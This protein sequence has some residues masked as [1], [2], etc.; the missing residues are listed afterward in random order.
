MPR[1]GAAPSRDHAVLFYDDAAHA[2]DR[3]ADYAAEGLTRGE[4]VV[5]VLT[6]SH[7]D[8]LGGGLRERGFEPEV[9]RAD[10]PVVLLDAA[11]TLRTFVVDGTPDGSLSAAGS[12]RWFESWPAAADRFVPPVRWS[13][14][15]GSTADMSGALALEAA[16]ERACGRIGFAPLSP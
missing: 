4:A 7:A 14:S 9:A 16:L 12:A 11:S 6:P 3:L 2:V 5:A 10:R 15:S 13:P 1:S 8:A